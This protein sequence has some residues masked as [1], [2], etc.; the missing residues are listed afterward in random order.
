MKQFLSAFTLLALLTLTACGGSSSTVQPTSAPAVTEPTSAPAA[1]APTDTPSTNSAFPVTITHKYGDITIAQEPQRVVSLGYS[2]QD[3]LL[4]I[5]VVPVA[6]RD[7]F[8]NKPYGVWPWGEAALG[9]ATPELLKMPY[10][11]INIEKIASLKPDL[12]VATHSGIS[13][14]EYKLL[15]EIAPTLA[16]SGDYPD[17]GMP[18]QDQTRSIG[19]AVGRSE[20]AEAAIAATEKAISDARAAHPEFAAATLA[21]VSPAEPGSFWAVGPTTPP[22]RFLSS[23]GIQ[24]P[25]ELGEAVGDQDSLAIS[26]EQLDL[27]DGSLLVFAGPTLE[28]IAAILENPVLQQLDVVKGER[29]IPFA[30]DDAIYGS[31]SFSTVLSLPYA[32]ENLV[33]T[34]AEK[35]TGQASEASYPISIAHQFG[36]TEIAAAPERVIALGYTDADAMLALDSVPIAVRYWFGDQPNGVW[37]WAQD[38][39][40]NAK[41]E[42]L[43]MAF[44]ELNL[45]TIAA[46]KPDLILAVSAGISEDEYKLL[47]EIAPT[48][49]QSAD[50]VSMGVPWDEQT[51]IIGKALGKEQLAIQ[52][53]ADVNQRYE[54][55]RAQYPEF[56]GKS[57]I[58]AMPSF[59]GSDFLFSGPQHERQRFLSALGFELPAELVQIAGESFYGS[60]SPE[61]ID[62]FN[63]DVLIWT[64]SES[65]RA[66]LE[67]NAVYQQLQVA[68]EGRA[69]YLD[70]SGQGDLAGPA[71]VFATA[72]SIPFAIDLIAPQLAS[73]IDGDPQTV[74]P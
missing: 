34:I 9:D 73:A 24:Y 45:E 4:A 36:T 63:A 32:V 38:K 49:A 57:A 20:Q 12:I 50:Y 42:V 5:G 27:I 37:P 26:S 23:L 65:E 22:M 59:S 11:E 71:L 10:G 33:P 54:Q 30:L 31:L 51:K 48:L 8:G 25:K 29:V 62:L 28:E 2:E 16:Q 18:W 13:E 15:Q 17:F 14:A 3:P 67:Q 47:S 70:A 46:L 60:I 72:L 39:L 69:L 7:W 21:W 6:I 53:V 64:V 52:V 43:N 56:A 58:V 74:A 35:L 1:A 55:A 61:R 40:G 41:P 68:K 66:A 19:E 44:G